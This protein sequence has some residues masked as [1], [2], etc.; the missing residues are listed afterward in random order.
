MRIL[1]CF[2]LVGLAGGIFRFVWSMTMSRVSRALVESRNGPYETS[3]I[4]APLWLLAQTYVIFAWAAICI[5]I[6]EVCAGN[7]PVYRGACY[8]IAFLGCIAA[9]SYKSGIRS[10][11]TYMAIVA[12]IGFGAM[13]LWRTH[14]RPWSWILGK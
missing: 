10:G 8:V 12:A 4:A 5:R 13:L 11:L 9:F 14:M 1:G 2:L 7:Q 6:A 3:T